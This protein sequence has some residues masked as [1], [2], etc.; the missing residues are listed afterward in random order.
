[1]RQAKVFR[2]QRVTSVMTTRSMLGATLALTLSVAGSAHA[3]PLAGKGENIQPIATLEIDDSQK[4]ELELAGDYAYVDHD[5]GMDIVDISD[6]SKPKTVGELKCKGSGGDIDLSTDATIAVRATAHDTPGCKEAGTAASIVDI[7]DKTKPRIIGKIDLEEAVDPFGIYGDYVHTVT[8]DGDLLYLNPQ[9]AGFYPQ[10]EQRIRIFDI[11]NPAKPVEKGEV[12]SGDGIQ[13]LAHDSFVDHRPDGKDLLYGASVHTTD[14]FDV[15]DPL[16]SSVL[17]R[18]VTPDMTISH[19][20]QP[21]HDRSLLI[22]SD[23]SAVGD[24][25]A[26][27][28]CGKAGPADVGSTHF[29]KLEEDGTIADN[30]LAPVGTF[31]NGPRMTDGYCTSHVFWPAPDQNRLVQAWYTEGAR[32]IDFSDPAN[33][34]ELGHFVADKPTMY[35]SAKPHRGYIFA[36]DMDRGLDVLR[37]TGEGGA[38][39]PTTAGPAEV[40]RAGFQGVPYKPLPNVSRKGGSLPAPPAAPAPAPAAAGGTRAA[41]PGAAGST[42]G[43][44]VGRFS[45]RTKLKGVRRGSKLTVSFLN[46]NGKRIAARSFRRGKSSTVRISGVAQAGTYRY[47]IKRGRKTVKRGRFTVKPVAGLALSPRTTLTATVR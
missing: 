21:N 23:E 1:M 47:A 25:S 34:K 40:Q 37:Y 7:S 19:Q 46:T 2:G 10:K 26:G 30:G 18:T 22:V 11:S 5:D 32:V 13:A 4:N 16:N 35:W 31:N 29:F 38:K 15:T 8:L 14:V 39:W 42:A 17:Q 20:A 24:N 43:R 36:T 41:A 33:P 9:I 12:K 44:A 6:P 3:A 27:W 28:A 45:L